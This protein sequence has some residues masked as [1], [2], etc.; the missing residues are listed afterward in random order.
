MDVLSCIK[1]LNPIVLLQAT[2]AAKAAAA[3][4]ARAATPIGT[5]R[6]K[7]EPG[8]AAAEATA[9]AAGFAAPSTQ[10]RSR[11][12]GTSKHTGGGRDGYAVRQ[13]ILDDDW[14]EDLEDETDQL[15]KH[16]TGLATSFTLSVVSGHC[17]QAIHGMAHWEKHVLAH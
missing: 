2:R 5:V 16:A 3:A 11:E 17:I 12:P 1:Q 8:S 7:P 10:A 6:V 14:E 9:G 4:P 15:S 13:S